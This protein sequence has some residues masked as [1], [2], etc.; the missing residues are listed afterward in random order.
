MPSGILALGGHLK[1]TAALTLAKGV[2]VSQHLG[3]LDTRRGPRRLRPRPRRHRPPARDRTRASSSAISTPTIFRAAI[4]ETSGLPVVAVQHHL[5]HVVACMAE[6]GLEPPVLGVAW[7]GTGYGPDGTVWGGE[8]LHVT[9]AGWRRVAHLRP[10]RLPGGEAAMREPRR[11]AL[12][13]LYAAYGRGCLTMTDLAPVAGLRRSRA[14]RARHMLER[15]INAPM[16]TSAGRLFDAV[17]ALL[18]LRQQSSY[19]GQAAMELEWA[20][21][22]AE[23]ISTQSPPKLLDSFSNEETGSGLPSPHPLIPAQAGTQ[24]VSV[25]TDDQDSSLPPP[26]IGDRALDALGP[27]SRLRGD[28]R[29][30]IARSPREGRLPPYTIAAGGGRPRSRPDERGYAFPILENPGAPLIVDWAPALGEIIADLRT[31]AP[32]STISARFHLGLAAAIAAVAAR[33]GEERVVLTG[34]CFQ[35]A[36]LTEAAIGALRAAGLAPYWHRNVPPNDGG[37]ALGQALWAA[38]LIERGEVAC[39]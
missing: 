31:G 18:G 15:G 24:P 10:F 23:N 17:A 7:D 14:R 12:G 8:F 30:G 36:F 27:R 1:T 5:A 19:E 9:A 16:T 39:A 13:L 3:D 20:I 34:G 33:I 35:N 32:P 4:A 26:L 28:E 37:L 38:S 6:H 22:K 2:V 25:A 21:D 29:V 11:S